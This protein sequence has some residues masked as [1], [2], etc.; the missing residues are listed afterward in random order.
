MPGVEA[1]PDAAC[2][3]RNAAF[4]IEM[5]RGGQDRYRAELTDLAVMRAIGEPA[6]QV[7]LDAGCGEGY[8]SRELARLGAKTIGVDTSRTL[9]AA[10]RASVATGDRMSF[11]VGDFRR[12]CELEIPVVDV[13]VANLSINDIADPTRAFEGFANAL[14][15]TGRL[16]MLMLHPC[17]Y[18]TPAHSEAPTAGLETAEHTYFSTRRLVKHFEIAGRRSPS[19]STRYV[20][21]L[22]R[23]L[24]TLREAGFREITLTEPAPSPE[25]WADP[26]WR[27]YLRRPLFLLV[28]ARPGG[29]RRGVASAT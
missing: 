19:P 22:A 3:E 20:R 11:E 6:G 21:P 9:I 1:E 4:W 8:L 13:V 10:A 17:F 29:A 12:L 28:E 5:M 15:P 27:D 2:W 24:A 16:V 14:T 25:Q 7:I 23:D 26:W 18:G